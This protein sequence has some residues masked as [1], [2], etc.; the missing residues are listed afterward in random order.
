MVWIVT[1]S[2]QQL[3][4]TKN[5]EFRHLRWP[6]TRHLGQSWT[7]WLAPGPARQ[8]GPSRSGEPGRQGLDGVTCWQSD[9]QERRASRLAARAPLGTLFDTVL[10]PL[11]PQSED[12]II[13]RTATGACVPEN[14]ASAGFTV[15]N[16]S[17]V[18]DK[19]GGLRCS[20]PSP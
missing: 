19:C 5:S 2:C 16:E 14:T 15:G 1:G 17:V 20:S 7:G 4:S 3:C 13:G 9:L 11:S 18:N 10:S 12:S 6:C 8:V